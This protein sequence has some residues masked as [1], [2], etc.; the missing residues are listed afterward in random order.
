LENA[1]AQKAA[2]IRLVALDVDGVLTDGSITLTDSGEQIKTF[3]VR[4]G[5]GIKYLIRAGLQVALITGRSSRCVEYRAAELGVEYVFQG[6]KVK[7]EPY[8]A[9]LEMSGL[10]D[11]QVACVGDDLP[12]LPLLR[13]CGLAV[14]VADAAEEVKAAAD[15]VTAAAGGR[16]AAREVAELILKAQGKWDTILRRYDKDGSRSTGSG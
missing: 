13:R 9:L 7:L 10:S 8:E 1:A 16:G 6:A 15:V 3:H 4:D 5:T 2:R 12:D 11:A 14:A